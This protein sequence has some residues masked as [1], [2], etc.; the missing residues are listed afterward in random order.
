MSYVA[1]DEV[2]EAMDAMKAGLKLAV[3]AERLRV[4]EASLRAALGLP[5]KAAMVM[6]E[7]LGEVDLW[8]GLDRLERI[9]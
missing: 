5:A 7:P 3:I 8:S 9:L 1:G 4:S 2:D 6:P